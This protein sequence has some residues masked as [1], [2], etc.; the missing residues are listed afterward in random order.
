MREGIMLLT[1]MTEESGLEPRSAGNLEKLEKA[2]SQ[3]LPPE[4]PEGTALQTHVR[5][6]I[7]RIVK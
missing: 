1:L 6:L 7:S 3:L 5:L 2:R 4:P